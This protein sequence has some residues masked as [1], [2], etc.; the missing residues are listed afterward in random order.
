M[1]RLKVLPYK[2]AEF[3]RIGMKKLGFETAKVQHNDLIIND[4]KIKLVGYS[5]YP[6][7]TNEE[8]E[9]MDIDHLYETAIMFGYNPQ[10][11]RGRNLTEII[12]NLTEPIAKKKLKAYVYTHPKNHIERV[13]AVM[14]DGVEVSL[15][16]MIELGL[17]LMENGVKFNV[18]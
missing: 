6:E 10:I 16:N 4:K 2:H 14:S 7:Y 18:V 12:N 9:S 3:V 1:R 15:T 17:S 11:H 13:H 5:E 8:L